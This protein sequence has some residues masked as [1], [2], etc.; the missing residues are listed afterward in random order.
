MKIGMVTDSLAHLSFD[1][2]LR[3][4]A[5]LGLDC[6]EFP[7]GNWSAAPH[8]NIDALLDSDKNRREFLARVRDHGLE[9]SALTANGNPLHPKSG[10]EQDACLRKTIRL[11]ALMNIE[12]VNAMSGLPGGRGDAN[13]NWVTVAWPPDCHEILDYQWNEVALPYWQE[14][15]AF[16]NN[17]G[18]HKICLE[19]HGGQLVYNCETF[20][21]LRNAV[22]DTVG[23][24]LD[25]SH[26]LWMGADPIACVRE[27]GDAIYHVHAKD[28]LIDNRNCAINSRLETAHSAKV[29]ERS[30]SYVTLGYGQ[31]EGW[32]KRFC[33]ALRVVGYDDVLSIEHED[34]TL[35]RL[36]GV[37]KSIELLKRSIALE[38]S[39]YELPNI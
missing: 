6:V 23:V 12:R 31:D 37:R 26:L 4:S 15:V 11:A 22:G 36:E 13:P 32:W 29:A 21:R 39:D 18:I 2:L 16:S 5:E 19:L 33:Y 7:T 20:N 17:A 34:V 24:N 3:Q 8:I 30:W 38:A 9:I 25:P 28:A 27:L 35:S 14:L 1:E 10:V